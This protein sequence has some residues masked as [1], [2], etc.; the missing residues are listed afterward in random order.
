MKVGVYVD[1]SNISRNGGRG[2]KYEV[3]AKFACR[4][5]GEAV[6]LNTYI[7]FD[8]KRAES[9][10]LYR[11]RALN[12]Q[13]ALREAE[14]KV[15]QKQVQW[16][17][18]E[19]GNKVSK[20]NADLDMAVD[21]LL[22]SDKLDRVTL[23]TGDGDF[24]QVVKALQNKGCRVEVIAFENVSGALKREADVFTSGYLIPNLLPI[25]GMKT[26]EW[27]RTKGK[28]RGMCYYHNQDKPFGFLRFM[29][30]NDGRFDEQNLYFYDASLPKDITPQD[31]PSRSLVF[32]FD[33]A[34]STQRGR[35]TEPVATNIKT[36]T[37]I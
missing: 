25:E 34:F 32:E 11:R 12:Y 19:E 2:M 10:A 26:T 14:F 37:K 3:L 22:Q 5:G 9:D 35:E 36:I 4:D 23:C 29:I 33:I 30:N 1:D 6:R 21:A 13:A 18:D 8:E 16:F 28:A 20:A 15:V 31:L 17:T 27:G 24:C 7:A